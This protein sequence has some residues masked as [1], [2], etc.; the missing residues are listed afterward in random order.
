MC[1]RSSFVQLADEVLNLVVQL[2]VVSSRRATKAV[3]KHR[4]EVLKDRWRRRMKVLPGSSAAVL[5]CRRKAL[6]IHKQSASPHIVCGI[7]GRWR[8]EAAAPLPCLGDSGKPS[9]INRIPA[10]AQSRRKVVL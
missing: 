2:P 8:L 3:L 1:A 5:G 6:G 9:A 10:D 4:F 7:F